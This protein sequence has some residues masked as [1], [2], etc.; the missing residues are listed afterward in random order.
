[1]SNLDSLAPEVL[2]R[3]AENLGDSDLANLSLVNYHLADSF[4]DTLYDRSLEDKPPRVVK[5]PALMWAIDYGHLSLVERII[6]HPDFDLFDRNMRDALHLAATVGHSA[7]VRALVEYG[8]EVDARDKH[9]RTPLHLAA[10][11][12]NAH[13]AEALIDNGADISATDSSGQTPI[14]IAIRAPFEP[15]S[16]I[17]S[18]TSKVPARD[19]ELKYEMERRVVSTVQSLIEMGARAYLSTPN[20]LG[21]TPLHHAVMTCC[22][23]S[24]TDRSD[25]VVGSGVIKMLVDYK[26]DYLVCNKDNDSAIDLS[27]NGGAA[28]TTALNCFLDRGLDPNSKTHAGQSFIL[29][30]A[31]I[32]TT[33][34]A[35]NTTELLLKRGARI[36]FG[37]WDIFHAQ[38]YPNEAYFDKLLTLLLIHGAQFNGTEADCF[39]IAVYHGMLSVM[40]MLLEKGC[41]INATMSRCQCPHHGLTAL[42]VAIARKNTKVLQFLVDNKVRMTKNKKRQVMRII[43]DPSNVAASTPLDPDLWLR[44]GLSVMLDY[45]SGRRRN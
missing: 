21:N 12:G 42:Q 35:Y 5:I 17:H 18:A 14:V 45:Q 28:G 34:T 38:V 9:N 37:L 27:V 6:S 15:T 7:I 3:I 20:E 22:A 2:Q 11:H 23:L 32:Q 13:A 8:W 16:R 36:D 1:M 4:A 24:A 43:K 33:E 39:I 10:F 26:A 40:K 30:A 25:L 31:T 44:T 41:D 29:A 19:I